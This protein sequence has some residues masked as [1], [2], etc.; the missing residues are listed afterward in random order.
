MIAICSLL[1]VWVHITIIV[2][3]HRA[4]KSAE[5][6][7]H[8]VAFLWKGYERTYVGLTLLT[9]HNRKIAIRG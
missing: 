9:A 3:R 1:C 7:Y 8:F 4:L 6:A 5:I 2:G